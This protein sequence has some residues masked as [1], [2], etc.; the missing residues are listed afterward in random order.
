LRIARVFP[1]RTNATPTDSLAFIGG[2]DLFAPSLEI[3]R[4]HIACSENHIRAVCAML[5]KQKRRPFFTGGLEA[6]R[7]KPWHV[8]ELAKLNPVEIFFAYDTPNDREPL[9]EAGKMLTAAGF[10]SCHPLRVYVLSDT[11]ATL[12]T[13]LNTDCTIASPR[14]LCLWRCCTGTRPE[15]VIRRGSD[16]RGHGRGRRWYT[17]KRK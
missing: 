17:Q 16:L 10:K 6:A 1:R 13:K 14:V 4:V 5:A 7:L 3:D 2:P 11:P 8:G 9:Y 12:S 15:S